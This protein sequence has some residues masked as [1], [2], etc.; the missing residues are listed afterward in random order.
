MAV[1]AT[2]SVYVGIGDVGMYMCL[3]K[4][5]IQVGASNTPLDIS[6]PTWH[7]KAL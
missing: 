2:A 5:L 3:G 6:N 7:H 1:I 4:K